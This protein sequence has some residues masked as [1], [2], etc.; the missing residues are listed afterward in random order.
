MKLRNY[1][2]L[3]LS[4]AGFVGCRCAAPAESLELRLAWRRREE[5]DVQLG[6]RLELTIDNVEQEWE[7]VGVVTPQYTV[8]LLY[9]G[10]DDLSRNVGQLTLANRVVVIVAREAQEPEIS[11]PQQGL[12][13]ERGVEVLDREVGVPG[14]GDARRRAL[15]RTVRFL[16]RRQATP[17]ETGGAHAARGLQAA[18]G[19]GD[20]V[21][22]VA[23]S[24][25]PL[26]TIQLLTEGLGFRVSGLC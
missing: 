19:H 23:L 22:I 14:R 11:L 21:S 6:D 1:R 25:T 16:H 18:G 7:V 24:R 15:N 20:L 10:Y 4:L 9:A 13:V 12:V 17:G 8:P 26:E 2:P 3:A 5:T